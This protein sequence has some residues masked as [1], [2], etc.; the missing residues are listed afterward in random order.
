MKNL[1]KLFVVILAISAT[2]TLQAQ[3][4]GI[5][6]GVNFANILAKD[7][8]ETYSDDFKSLLGFHAGVTVDFPFTDMLAFQT[9]ALLSQKG[10]KFEE[11]EGGFFIKNKTTI[12]YVDIPLH[13]KASFG[14]GGLNIYA[15]AGPYVGIGLSGKS[16][17]E[18]NFGGQTEKEEEDI[19]FGSGDDDDIK[20]L[21]Y[22]LSVGAGVEINNQVSLGATYNLGLANLSNY[23][24][25][26]SK[27]NNRVFQISVGYKF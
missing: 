1:L 14:V 9:G 27:I 3:E 21:D 19:S 22:G 4:I 11:S 25:N 24:D 20:R 15:L 23:T 17:Y 18:Y 13:L 10:Y 7:N 6:G 2:S 12:N 26:G 5:K 16:K 8:D